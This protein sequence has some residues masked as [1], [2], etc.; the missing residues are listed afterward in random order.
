MVLSAGK[1]SSAQ[2]GLPPDLAPTIDDI[3]LAS[4][5]E[6]A[7]ESTA[8]SLEVVPESGHYIQDDRPQAVIDG[9]ERILDDLA[10]P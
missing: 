2:L 9:L 10:T 3:W 6:L 8:G 7:D 4:H 5:Q 1:S